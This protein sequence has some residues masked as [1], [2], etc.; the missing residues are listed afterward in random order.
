MQ[1]LQQILG[2][3]QQLSIIG[4]IVYAVIYTSAPDPDLRLS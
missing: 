3:L 2:I 1:R 4:G